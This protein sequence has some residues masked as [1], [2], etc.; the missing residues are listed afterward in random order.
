[1]PDRASI[2]QA[3]IEMLEAETDAKHADLKAK[4][5]QE[6]D[7]LAKQIGY[8]VPADVPAEPKR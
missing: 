3:L 8:T 7:A 2:R 6:H 5:E 1:M 4:L